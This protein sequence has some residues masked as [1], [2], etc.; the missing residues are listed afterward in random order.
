MNVQICYLQVCKL[1]IRRYFGGSVCVFVYIQV[2]DVFICAPGCWL[3]R[4]RCHN[5]D[6]LYKCI[7]KQLW[8]NQTDSADRPQ[9][10]F[11]LWI[12]RNCSFTNQTEL[13]FNQCFNS[14]VQCCSNASLYFHHVY[15]RYWA[16]GERRV[17]SNTSWAKHRQ[18][19]HLRAGRV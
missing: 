17:L 11:L 10:G 16:A 5:S 12:W 3:A 15:S 18:T 14:S 8:K 7:L 19:L 13:I 2:V 9:T 1:K 4:T 6:K